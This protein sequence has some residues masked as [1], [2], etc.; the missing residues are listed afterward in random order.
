MLAMAAAVMTVQCVVGEVVDEV[1][2]GVVAVVVI[3]VVVE[4]QRHLNLSEKRWG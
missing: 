1:V 4:C 3:V 2:G